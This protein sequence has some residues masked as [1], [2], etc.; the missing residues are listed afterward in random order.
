MT[1][2]GIPELAT[3]ADLRIVERASATAPWLGSSRGGW[4]VQFGREFNATDDRDA[5]VPY[6]GE[7][8]AR[9]VVE[10]KQVEPFRVSLVHRC[11]LELAPGAGS[12]LRVLPARAS[13]TAMSPARPIA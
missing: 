8:T 2:S 1:I 10:G 13:A 11:R 9:P 12:R 4:N 3:E 7:A 5:F 6:R